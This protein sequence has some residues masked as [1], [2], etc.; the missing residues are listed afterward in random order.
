[1]LPVAAAVVSGEIV[2]PIETAM[3][4]KHPG[5]YTVGYGSSSPIDSKARY[6]SPRK[7]LWRYLGF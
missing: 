7:V 5:T 6:L 2:H 3:L 4:N 1:M